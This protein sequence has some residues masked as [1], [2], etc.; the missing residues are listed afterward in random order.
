MRM[1]DTDG[2]ALQR[3]GISVTNHLAREGVTVCCDDETWHGGIS[4]LHKRNEFWS[5][6]C[7]RIDR[8][9]FDSLRAVCFKVAAPRGTQ[10]PSRSPVAVTEIGGL[11]SLSWRCRPTVSSSFS[12][13]F[14]RASNTE[15]RLGSKGSF[16]ASQLTRTRCN[17]QN[18]NQELTTLCEK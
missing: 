14:H 18:Q 5:N 15:S 16:C 9:V 10:T 6:S 3:E 4:L 7:G 11:G 12:S 13:L 17:N 8:P 2:R 1:A